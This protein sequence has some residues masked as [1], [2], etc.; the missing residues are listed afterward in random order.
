MRTFRKSL[1]LVR[2][3]SVA[4]VFIVSLSHSLLI[5]AQE[6]EPDEANAIL[7]RA[8]SS[9]LIIGTLAGFVKV[10]D[11][12][13]G[14]II[15][16]WE[17][18]FGPVQNMTWN[19]DETLLATAGTDGLIRT[20][21]VATGTLQHEFT[22]LDGSASAVAWHY[23]SNHVIGGSAYGGEPS[24]IIVWDADTGQ[25]VEGLREGNSAAFAWLPDQEFLVT[26]TF[27][28]ATFNNPWTLDNSIIEPFIASGPDDSLAV[29]TVDPSGRYLAVGF[30]NN[31]ARVWDIEEAQEVFAVET[32]EVD[33]PFVG[34]MEDHRT[35]PT[36]G[37]AFSTDGTRL[38][39]VTASGILRTWDASTGQFIVETQAP[40]APITAAAF[41]S[42]RLLLAYGSE[43]GDIGIVEVTPFRVEHP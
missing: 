6:A 8:D 21:E 14:E 1:P 4:A 11:I 32:M 3:I 35:V 23:E 38:Y 19:E 34:D 36:L 26:G 25:P 12:K 18:H 30:F 42:D 20:W 41:T 39:T 16:S 43:S 5:H 17:A 40:D 2:L 15:L 33:R 27:E 24:G 29:F 10:Q 9:Q 7:W 28:L 22:G 13:T 37:L 31:V